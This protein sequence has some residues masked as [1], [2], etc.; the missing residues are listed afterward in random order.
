MRPDAPSATVVGVTDDPTVQLLQELIRNACVNDGTAE[1]GHEERSVHTL[2]EY[3]G[4]EGEV[5][6]PAPG[7]QSVV[8]RVPG[9]D[10]DAPSLVLLPHLDVVPVNPE[11]WSVDP[12]AAEI[13]DGFVWGRGAVDMLNL[14]AAMATAFRPYLTGEK[15]MPGDLVFAAVAD[16]E[17]AGR[18]GAEYLTENHWDVVGG[19][20]LLTEVA[21]PSLSTPSGEVYP[22]SVGEKGPFWTG[23][24]TR[25]TPGHGSAPYG[26]RNA[27]RPMVE[28]LHGVFSTPMPVSISDEW[29]EFVA[30]LDL[31]ADLAEALV[32]PDRVDEAIDRLAVDDPAFARYVHAATHLT[33][34]PNILEGGVKVN[35]VPDEAR[36]ELDMRGL[37]G[38]DRRFVDEHLRKAMGAAADQ[39]EIVPIDDFPP[40]ASERGNPLWESIA[41]AIE[42]HTGSRRVV[43]ALMTVATDARFFRRRGTVAYGVGLYDGRVEFGEFLSL[44]HGNDERVTV[45]SVIRTTRLLETVL[46]RFAARA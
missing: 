21:Y 20:Y 35:V 29:R 33:I 6:E 23:L 8:Y 9:S 14:T 2:A 38:M 12:F 30:S 11:G 36:A 32:D 3:F 22:V 1:S 15:T 37:P 39:V 28:A 42:H 43:P 17:N 31:D 24:A 34:S 25:G 46:E 40:T 7:R 13:A 4:V 10:P 27:L 44:F 16:E 41:D 5:F 19:D 45:E 18:L 26:S